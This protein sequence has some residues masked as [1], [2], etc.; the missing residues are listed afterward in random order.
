MMHEEEVSERFNEMRKEWE[1]TT[2]N[3]KK[4]SR[5]DS[6]EEQTVKNGRIKDIIS[7]NDWSSISGQKETR[8][9][10]EEES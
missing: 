1:N 3:Q 2:K 9:L 4:D 6:R 10:Q 8:R 5:D 7:I